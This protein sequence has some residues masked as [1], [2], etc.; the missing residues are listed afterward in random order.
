MRIEYKATMT[1]RVQDFVLVHR[2]DSKEIAAVHL[3]RN[4]FDQMV[5]EVYP[6]SSQLRHGCY[7]RGTFSFGNYA[8]KRED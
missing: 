2:H 6:N 1:E 3:P 7:Q 8:I 5:R 4:D